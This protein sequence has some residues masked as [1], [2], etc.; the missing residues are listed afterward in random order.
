VSFRCLDGSLL[1]LFCFL[2]KSCLNLHADVSYFLCS[3]WERDV[4]LMLLLIMFQ[5]PNVSLECRDCALIKCLTVSI[6]RN[7]SAWLS[8]EN[9]LGNLCGMNSAGFQLTNQN[10]RLCAAFS[11]VMK[12][13]DRNL[14]QRRGELKFTRKSYLHSLLYALIALYL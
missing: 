10:V 5:Y 14:V 11:P 2:N 13:N 12:H 7:N 9:T 6:F 4:C 8:S 3:T 1:L